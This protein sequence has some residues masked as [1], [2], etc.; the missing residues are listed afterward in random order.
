[1]CRECPDDTL[2]AVSVVVSYATM[3]DA[4]GS[5][6]TA[7]P[8]PLHSLAELDDFLEQ[9]EEVSRQVSGLKSGKLAPD[10]VQQRPKKPQ[11]PSKQGQ[12][13]KRTPEQEEALRKKV[14]ALLAQRQAREQARNRFQQYLEV[15]PGD[16][17]E[18]T[19]YKKWDL[20]LPSDDE[21][22]ELFNSQ[23]PELKALEKDAE[24]RHS[25]CQICLEYVVLL[26]Q[27]L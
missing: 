16:S 9:A 12:P 11:V 4:L 20:F 24:D 13:D 15:H 8:A 23:R 10:F 3:H 26:C 14:Q 6:L 25:R 7:A 19:D 2:R 21:E 17:H 1:M 22:D 27:C 5:S 18:S